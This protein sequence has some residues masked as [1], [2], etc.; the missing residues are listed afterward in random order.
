MVLELVVEIVAIEES[1]EIGDVG[2]V[3]DEGQGAEELSWLAA[4][5]GL[6]G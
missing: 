3:G 6:D 4:W 2:L 1:I 5:S